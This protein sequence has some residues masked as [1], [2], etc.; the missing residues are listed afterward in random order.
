MVEHTTSKTKYS[1]G[2]NLLCLDQMEVA[3]NMHA[4]KAFYQVTS[5]RKLRHQEKIPAYTFELKSDKMKLLTST[6]IPLCRMIRTISLS[7]FA[8]Y[9]PENVLLSSV[10]GMSLWA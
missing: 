2:T 10:L 8:H 6:V 1:T 4:K 9:L 3:A 7:W 5:S